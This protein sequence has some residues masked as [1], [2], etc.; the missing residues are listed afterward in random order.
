MTRPIAIVPPLA[1]ACLLAAAPPDDP[2]K[3]DPG[4]ESA[5]A[6]KAGERTRAEAAL[7]RVDVGAEPGRIATLAPASVLRWSNPV[8][9]SIHGEVFV[10]TDR[11]CPALVGSIYKWSAP[12]TH[13][14][15]ELHALTTGPISADRRGR[16]VWSPGPADV[17]RKPIPGAPAPAETP[18]ARL[19]QARA[20][21]LEFSAKETT[22]EGVPRE[23]R[24]LTR[25]IYRA[26]SAD[27]EII[28]AALFAF[29]EGTDPEVILIIEARKGPAGAE[30][31]FAAARLN[32]VDLRLNHKGREAWHAPEIPWAQA[33]DHAQAYTLYIYG[34]DPGI[35]ADGPES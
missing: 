9:G 6:A 19:R 1:L 5:R 4:V 17:A 7:Y 3:A 12:Q 16:T 25:P 11:G 32:S 13:L 2:P 29:V 20:L 30:W 34:S 18:E 15:V 22:R 23:L 24:L 14:G 10:W 28:D 33:R 26:E 8:V 27:P 35:P 31:R 21:A